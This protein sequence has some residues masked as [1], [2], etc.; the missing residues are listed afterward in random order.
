MDV[1]G[2]MQFL[3]EHKMW[4]AALAPFAIAFIVIKIVG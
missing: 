4:L 2:I 1:Q 3:L